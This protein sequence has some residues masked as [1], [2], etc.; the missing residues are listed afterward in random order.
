VGIV[1][2]FWVDT[3]KAQHL[4][5]ETVRLQAWNDW[6]DAATATAATLHPTE[7]GDVFAGIPP[8]NPFATAG[9][10]ALA[11]HGDSFAGAGSYSAGSSPTPTPTPKQPQ[12]A[13]SAIIMRDRDI[14]N[15]I[16]DALVATDVFDLGGVW[17][18]GSPEDSGSGTSIKAAAA[19]EPGSGSVDDEWDSQGWGGVLVNGQVKLTLY[20]RDDD[21]QLRDEGAELLLYTANN[22]LNGQSLA[23]LTLP[24]KTRFSTWTW[25]TP[26]P[27]ERQI[28]CLFK[29]AYIVEGWDAHD[30]TE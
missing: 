15:A 9:S 21:A 25:A 19:I 22:A 6:T 14:R 26:A 30:T 12:P 7:R 17:I 11:G 3:Q 2:K 4:T 24:A 27:P 13:I 23:R 10:M 5:N 8:F 16:N 29:Y 28:V 20:Y 18:T 1:N